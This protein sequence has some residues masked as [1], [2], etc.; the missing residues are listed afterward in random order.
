MYRHL[1][2]FDLKYP[3]IIPPLHTFFEVPRGQVLEDGEGGQVQRK[4]NLLIEEAR[5]SSFPL[6][7]LEL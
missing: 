7:Q 1:A 3:N 6:C 5:L 2:L 4:P